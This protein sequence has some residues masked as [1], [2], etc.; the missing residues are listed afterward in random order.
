MAMEPSKVVHDAM[1]DASAEAVIVAVAPVLQ[2]WPTK[3]T[4]SCVRQTGWSPSRPTIV[5]VGLQDEEGSAES[6]LPSTVL[7]K[8]KAG[9]SNVVIAIA[10]GFARRYP[11]NR[12][13]ISYSSVKDVKWLKP[14]S[15]LMSRPMNVTQRSRAS[16][17]YELCWEG[18]GD[19]NQATHSK[20]RI[21]N[22]LA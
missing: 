3:R 6:H 1:A 18:D 8:A 17:I 12:L 5:K 10:D 4:V 7:A 19:R 22:G 21:I 2:D 16:R 11:W 9:R 20:Q 15:K 13:R 14:V